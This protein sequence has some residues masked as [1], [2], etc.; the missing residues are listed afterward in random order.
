MNLSF[1]G[2]QPGN[3]QLRIADMAGRTVL[4]QALRINQSNDLRSITLPD[5][6]PACMRLKY[7]MD[8]EEGS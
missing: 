3:Y 2:V 1:S 4:E 7:G 5:L 8:G 6:A